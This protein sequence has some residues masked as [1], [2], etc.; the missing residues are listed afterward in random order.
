MGFATCGQELALWE[1]GPLW[2]KQCLRPCIRAGCLPRASAGGLLGASGCPGPAL[3][4]QLES[5]L[6]SPPWSIL[7]TE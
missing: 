7:N 6:C 4:S 1:T 3:L 5:V 2:A